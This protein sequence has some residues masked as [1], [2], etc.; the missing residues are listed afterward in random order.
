MFRVW[1]VEHKIQKT[2]PY[3]TFFPIED[4]KATELMNAMKIE[5]GTSS[6]HPIAIRDGLADY[7]F[8]ENWLF[9]FPSKE[10]ALEWFD[11]YL[12]ELIAFDFELKEFNVNEIV[13]S[14]SGR[15]LVFKNE[16]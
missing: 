15:Q 11:G 4:K 12:D 7:L 3:N 13:M 10:L 5:H 14:T 9:A 16:I 8:K 1:R 6:V 2:G